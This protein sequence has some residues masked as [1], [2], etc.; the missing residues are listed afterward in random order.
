MSEL[1]K[2]N[3]KKA[4]FTIPWLRQKSFLHYIGKN[5][6]NTSYTVTV[7]SNKYVQEVLHKEIR[8]KKH[9]NSSVLVR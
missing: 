5:K 2:W 3:R 7:M 4:T 9:H 6:F 1:Q 8:T